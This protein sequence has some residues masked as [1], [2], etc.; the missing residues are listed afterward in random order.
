MLKAVRIMDARIPKRIGS[1]GEVVDLPERY[2]AKWIRRGLVEDA[3]V[4]EPE[5]VAA[6]AEARS[7]EGL[8]YHEL[9]SLAA[10]LP[11]EHE[12]ASQRK[13]DLLLALKA[14][15]Y[16]RRDLRAEE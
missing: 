13:G 2:A 8:E 15:T 4:P 7:L 12:P 10:E 9:R 5:R 16:R 11:E 3:D 14:D 6:V 1:V